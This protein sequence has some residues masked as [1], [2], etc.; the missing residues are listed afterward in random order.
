MSAVTQLPDTP[1]PTGATG[2][3]A[4]DAPS[5]LQAYE[6]LSEAADLVTRA[7]RLLRR[8]HQLGLGFQLYDLA[9]EI[10]AEIRRCP[11]QPTAP[12]RPRFPRNLTTA[13]DRAD[14]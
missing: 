11:Y 4:G 12:R 14:S 13:P 2:R 3:E 8:A 10:H 9:D 1:H 6:A 7:G 5:D